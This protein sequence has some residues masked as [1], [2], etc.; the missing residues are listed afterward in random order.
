M[1][2]TDGQI[3]RKGWIF[4]QL[5]KSLNLTVAKVIYGLVH[6]PDWEEGRVI[7]FLQFKSPLADF[8]I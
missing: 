2:V 8:L 4:Q 7:Y 1:K 5:Y 3:V 6:D